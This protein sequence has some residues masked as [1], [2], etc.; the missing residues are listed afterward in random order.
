MSKKSPEESREVILKLLEALRQDY[1]RG[2]LKLYKEYLD[3]DAVYLGVGD[4]RIHKGRESC[5]EYLRTSAKKGLMRAI[6]VE[7]EDVKF[8]GDVAIVVESYTT[9]YKIK[10]ESFR[11]TGRGTQVL[12]N[13]DGHWYVTHIQLERLAS[14][15]VI[16]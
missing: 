1:L 12:V 2:S 5:L 6:E 10:G 13:R 3:E 7:A 14:N 16:S 15:R 9:K 4:Y 11:D 8:I